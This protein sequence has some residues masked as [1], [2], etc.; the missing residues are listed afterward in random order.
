[1]TPSSVRSGLATRLDTITGV[2]V[3]DYI[4]D[5]VP[6]PCAVVGNLTI[7]F[8]ESF[9]RGL[10]MGSVDCLLIVSRMNERGAQDK[11]DAYL[12][13][14]GAGSVKAAVEADLTL[15]GSVATCRVTRA[16]PIE[17]DVSGIK[18][19]AYRYEVEVYG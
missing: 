4:P 2:R 19:F 8:D 18:Y 13:G 7:E 9:A 15:S 11:L 5:S 1:M 6:T 3:F 14:S 10:D 12:A 16:T 17:V